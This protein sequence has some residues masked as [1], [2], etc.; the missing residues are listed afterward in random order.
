MKRLFATLGVVLGLALAGAPAHAQ[1]KVDVSAFSRADGSVKPTATATATP[2]LPTQLGGG[3]TITQ[4]A[5]Q[6]IIPLTGVA[7][8]TPPNSFYRVFDLSQT[9]AAGGLTVQSVDFGVESVIGSTTATVTLHR[10][11]GPFVLANLTQVA[12]ETVSLS[13]ADD[14]TLVNVA[15]N[16][17][18]AGSDM[19]VLEVAVP[20][21]QFYPGS[22]SAGQTGPTYVRSSVCGAAEP[23]DLATL[24]FPEVHWVVNINGTTEPITGPSIFASPGTVGFGR[25]PVGSTSDTRT[26]TIT[27]NGTEN[28]T[29]TSITGSGAPFTVNTAGTDLTLDPGQSTTFTATFSPTANGPASG[30]VTIASNAPNSP[31]VVAL[32]GEGFAPPPNDNFADAETIANPG[33]V[34]G[35]NAEATLEASESVPSCQGN[36]DASVWW[37][38]TPSA[39]GLLTVNLSASDFDTVLTLHDDT[40]TEQACDDDGGDGLTSLIA[41]FPVTAGEPVYIRVGGYAGATGAIS[42][43]VSFTGGTLQTTNF[44]GDTSGDPT[45]TRPTSVGDGTSG[46]CTLS[47]TATAVSYEALPMNVTEAG[48]YTITTTY[49][50]HDGYLFLYDGSFNA[51][52]PCL[53][54]IALNDDFGGIG[55][56]QILAT[57][58]PGSY[59]LVVTGFGNDD[60]GSYT[61]T[62][63]GPGAVVFPVGTEGGPEGARVSLSASP[64]PASGTAAVRLTVEAPQTIAVALYDVTGRRV[65]TLFDGTVAGELDLRVDTGAFPAGVYVIRATGSD[66]SLTERLTVVR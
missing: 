60:A 2:S 26:V 23:T 50:G 34:T 56:S 57:L 10:L 5:S 22:N 64:N 46:S 43:D 53:N 16:A 6:D 27:N 58:T 61:G 30:T 20:D 14:L 13:A 62:V 47:G 45:W 24:S 55:G 32:T 31:T 66:V 4:N 63:V 29:I 3:V 36:Y 65:A 15:I 12:S 11:S 18:F 21:V 25:V 38:W 9:P 52:D 42:M 39:N 19:L 54:L 49:G 17:V 28:V 48:L 7:C 37:V 41:N 8:P 44:A 40:Q 35:T 1:S 33:T 51:A 59:T